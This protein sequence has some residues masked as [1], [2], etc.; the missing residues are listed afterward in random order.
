[1]SNALLSQLR[2][3][4]E[5]RRGP[6]PSPVTHAAKK[7][8]AMAPP[9]GAEIINLSSEDD[10]DVDNMTSLD[11]ALAARLQRDED[12]AWMRDDQAMAASL[13][14]EEHAH[15]GGAPSSEDVSGAPWPKELTWYELQ[16]EPNKCGNFDVCSNGNSYFAC[17]TRHNGQQYRDHTAHGLEPRPMPGQRLTIK[18]LPHDELGG[19]LAGIAAE[20]ARGLRV[21]KRPLA[22]GGERQ[23]RPDKDGTSKVVLA[24]TPTHTPFEMTAF[25]GHIERVPLGGEMAYVLRNWDGC[26]GATLAARLEAAFGLD[27]VAPPDGKGTMAKC[28]AAQGNNCQD[29]YTKLYP[30]RMFLEHRTDL[31]APLLR[32]ALD[33]VNAA[34]TPGQPALSIRRG[35]T[36]VPFVG[37]AQILRFVSGSAGAGSAGGGGGSGDGGGGGARMHVHVDKPGTRWVAILALGD[38][39]TFLLDHAPRCAPPIPL[40]PTPPPSTLLLEQASPLPTPTAPV[41]RRRSPIA[42]DGI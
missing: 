4:R 22:A 27:I 10:E 40:P 19:E 37:E 18:Y 7:A 24:R 8:K 30:L 29:N 41:L 23:P 26:K 21:G 15:Y 35:E 32:A 20:A 38:S 25:S 36:G 6:P 17:V 28:A 5:A 1:M 31:L 11:A 14:Q 33:A 42:T 39:S 34:A 16:H 13:Q 12:A 3:E 2:A 9:E